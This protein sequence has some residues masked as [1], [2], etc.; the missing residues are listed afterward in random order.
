GRT[1]HRD[2]P[3]RCA[4]SDPAAVQARAWAAAP[5]DQA[6]GAPPSAGQGAEGRGHKNRPREPAGRSAV[7]G[8]LGLV[9]ASHDSHAG[10]CP[11]PLRPPVGALGQ[12]TRPPARSSTPRAVELGRFELPTSRVQG[13]RSPTELQPR[14]PRGA[15]YSVLRTR[16]GGRAWNRT[17]DLS[18]IRTAL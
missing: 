12:Y 6:A 15:Q 1:P 3:S 2:A 10:R 8:A 14:S 9:A 16:P 4:S 13:G 11:F 5:S 17:R 7:S 18:L